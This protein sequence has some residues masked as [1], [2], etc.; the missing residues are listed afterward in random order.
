MEAVA[1]ANY[2]LDEQHPDG[3]TA[4][5]R[6]TVIGGHFDDRGSGPARIRVLALAAAGERRRHDHHA[7]RPLAEGRYDPG[8]QRRNGDDEQHD[9]VPG[10][11][12][13]FTGQRRDAVATGTVLVDGETL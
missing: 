11:T 7:R 10:F 4:Q 3:S 12:G 9:D 1:T 13:H 6:V 5:T 2:T 8:G